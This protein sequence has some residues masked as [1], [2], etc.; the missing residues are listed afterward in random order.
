MSVITGIAPVTTFT[1]LFT[2]LPVLLAL[3]IFLYD[4]VYVP[5]VPVFTMPL[6]KIVPDPSI[7]SVQFAHKSVKIDPKLTLMI[8]DPFSTVTGGVLSAT[9]TFLVT[10][11]AGFELLSVTLY[12]RI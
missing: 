2:V 5:R 8:E 12:E 9:I 10:V 6:Q 11:G 4:S 3:S 7:A 1:V